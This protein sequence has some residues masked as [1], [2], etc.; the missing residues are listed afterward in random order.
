MDVV[1]FLVERGANVAAVDKN[2]YTA[3][4]YASEEGNMDVVRFLVE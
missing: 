2:G 1:R 4:M 3:M